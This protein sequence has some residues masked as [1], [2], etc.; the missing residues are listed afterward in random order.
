MQEEIIEKLR[1]VFNTI[2]I[3]SHDKNI[4][5]KCDRIFKIENKKI[6]KIK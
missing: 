4:Q 5:N 6:I 1:E 2:I 3:S